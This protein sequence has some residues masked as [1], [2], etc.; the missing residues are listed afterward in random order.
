MS[1]MLDFCHDANWEAQIMLD[2][3]QI[4]ATVFVCF[5]ALNYARSG[6]QLIQVAIDM[7]LSHGKL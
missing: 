6:I 5:R 3:C 4:L 1:Q 7:P 2:G